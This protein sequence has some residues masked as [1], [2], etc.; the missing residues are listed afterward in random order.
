MD[1][2]DLL[3]YRA[4]HPMLLEA[5]HCVDSCRKSMGLC[6]DRCWARACPR[7][8]HRQWGCEATGR[9]RPRFR[10]RLLQVFRPSQSAHQKDPTAPLPCTVPTLSLLRSVIHSQPSPHSQQV[11][12]IRTCRGRGTYSTRCGRSSRRTGG[13]EAAMRILCGGECP[14][15]P[16]AISSLS[17]R[18]FLLS[19]L[20]DF[21]PYTP[22]QVGPL[23]R[24]DG[25]PGG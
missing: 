21:L 14:S 10:V 16:N 1:I 19:T 4:Q 23:S 7:V 18:L 20:T 13:V 12:A 3:T 5:G 8:L 11:S 2:I 17:K 22:L 6:W 9:C 24:V 15:S 25:R